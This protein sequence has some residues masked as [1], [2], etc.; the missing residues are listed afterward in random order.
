MVTAERLST[1]LL[2]TTVDRVLVVR[3]RDRKSARHGRALLKQSYKKGLGGASH[4]PSS[5]DDGRIT[6]TCTII[7]HIN[8]I[9][10]SS[11]IVQSLCA[12]KTHITDAASI[13]LA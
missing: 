12:A 1:D 7:I 4:H 8:N 9:S 3:Y 6:L 13:A 2:T 5:H 10:T 11:Y